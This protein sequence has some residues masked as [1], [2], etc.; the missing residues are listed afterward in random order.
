MNL[1]GFCSS[2]PVLI[3]Y[4]ITALEGLGTG[5]MLYIS[6]APSLQVRFVCM[7]CFCTVPGA[8]EKLHE[9]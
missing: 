3:R 8:S 6:L 5:K 1:K 9:S 7:L 4:A 2:Y